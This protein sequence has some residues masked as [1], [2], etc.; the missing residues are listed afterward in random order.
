MRTRIRDAVSI[1]TDRKS[2]THAYDSFPQRSRSAVDLWLLQVSTFG[3]QDSVFGTRVEGA[4]NFPDSHFWSNRGF[5]L[6]DLH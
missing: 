4:S 3:E 2:R 5:R 6:D 1:S